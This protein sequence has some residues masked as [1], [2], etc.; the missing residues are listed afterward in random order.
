M[1]SSISCYRV[2][3]ES[4]GGGIIISTSKGKYFNGF[5]TQESAKRQKILVICGFPFE[6]RFRYKDA[7]K[8]ICVNARTSF[9]PLVV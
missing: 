3:Q 6:K 4:L 9:L 1:V 5:C 8:F 7:A 2:K